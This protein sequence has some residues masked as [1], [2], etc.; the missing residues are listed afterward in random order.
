VI[1]MQLSH[2]SDLRCFYA[3]WWWICK[4]RG[5]RVCCEKRNMRL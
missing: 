3:W 1:K 5:A 2:S 4:A